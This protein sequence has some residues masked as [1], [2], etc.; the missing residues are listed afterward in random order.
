M[1]ELHSLADSLDL[2]CFQ[3]MPHALRTVIRLQDMHSKP[4]VVEGVVGRC[5]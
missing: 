2:C 5:G 4:V 1:L 3:G